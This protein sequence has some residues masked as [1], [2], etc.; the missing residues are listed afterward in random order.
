[1][2]YYFETSSAQAASRHAMLTGKT[3]KV[4]FHGNLDTA[5]QKIPNFE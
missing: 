5:L 2:A 4:C 3:Q 1:M